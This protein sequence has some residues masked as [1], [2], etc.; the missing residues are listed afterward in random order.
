VKNT[1]AMKYYTKGDYYFDI[2]HSNQ[3][4]IAGP[5]NHVL[6][7][8][9]FP[10]NTHIHIDGYEIEDDQ[11]I[12]HLTILTDFLTLYTPIVTDIRTLRQY[13]ES[14]RPAPTYKQLL[15]TANNVFPRII[16]ESPT[17]NGTRG[18]SFH[19]SYY[20]GQVEK[21]YGSE[22][23]VPAEYELDYQDNTISIKGKKP[24]NITIKTISN[25]AIS[26]KIT[27]PIFTETIGL[28]STIFSPFL[29]D[30]YEESRINIEHLVRAKKTS[31]FEYGTIFPRDWIESADLGEGDLAIETIDYM[32]GQSLKF[33]TEEG[34]G[35]H[36]DVVGEFKTKINIEQHIDRKM[37]DIEPHY[38]LGVPIVSKR[39]LTT[40][41]NQEKLQAV[42]RYIID[43]ARNNAL[44]TFKKMNS[45]SQEY[46]QV[47]NWRDG[48]FAFPGQR[49]PVA[50][51]DVNCVFYPQSLKII[52]KYHDYFAVKN[53]EELD[54]LIEKWSIIKHRFRLYHPNDILGYA[55]ALHSKKLIP[56]PI[57]HLDESY[58]LFYGEPN[59]EEVVSF[60]RKVI[61]PEFFYTPVGPILV[62]A[63]E[64]V[65]TTKE[66]HGKVIWPKQAAY[67]VA[68]LG[69]QLQRGKNEGWPQP[70]LDTV[71]NS[72][73]TT[74][75]ACFKGW[76][77]M[78]CVPELYYHDAE[79]KKARLYTDQPDYDG[80][81]SLIQLWSSVGCRR[82][83]REY[84]NVVGE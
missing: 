19:N 38:I 72:I 26:D 23:L 77:D 6:F 76:T 80:Q 82:I 74:C 54:D 20:D 1:K 43:N 75:Q 64:E 62:A 61:D 16:S 12:L 7:G 69:R 50:P 63:D 57:P 70:V 37:V 46:H 32:Y 2:D 10:E 56:L 45:E 27:T 66:Y 5:E 81:M 13:T 49:S 41:A 67:T 44:V 42:S 17:K 84:A 78:G 71:R 15:H 60:A 9:T 25:I 58:D 21:K 83:M 31:S 4:R 30:L 39:F 53:L 28:S 22:L 36:E 65:F 68:G 3:V 48:M 8:A 52:R 11:L 47:G 29:L 33:A 18:I 59:L 73:L 51:Y 79:Q 55:L 24:L 34:V 14:V 40:E 35:W